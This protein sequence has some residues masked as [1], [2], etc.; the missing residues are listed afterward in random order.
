MI[1]SIIKK[2]SPLKESDGIEVACS[3][4]GISLLSVHLYI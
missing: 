2:Y 4:A 1:T 3:S